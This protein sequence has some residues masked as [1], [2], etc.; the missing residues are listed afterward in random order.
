MKK[1]ILIFL[2][3]LNILFSAFPT[4]FAENE[5]P[6]VK[7]NIAVLSDMSTGK[8]LYSKNAAEKMQPGGFTKIMTAIVAIENMIDKNETVVADVNTLASYD[9]SFGHMGILAGEMLTLDNLLHGMLLYDAGDAAEVIANYTFS[10]RSKFIKKMNDKAVEIGALNTKFTNPTGFPD[11]KQYS[12]AEDIYKITKYAMDKEYFRDIVKRQRYEM[13]PTNK[14]KQNRY[15]DN[16]NKF[17]NST[18]TGGYYTSKAK[19]VKTSYI[20][21]SNC[22]VIIQY[23]NDN[24]KFMSI[25]SG[26]PFDGTTNYA[27]EDTSKLIKFASQYYA[28]VKVI[29]EEDILAEIELTNGKNADRLLL[30]ATEDI[31]INLPKG[32]DPK[33]LKT[34]V[35][36]EKNIKAPITKGKILGVVKVLYDG[37]EY[38]SAPLTSPIEVKANNIKG[39]FK[40]VWAFLT[41]PILLVSLGIL[42]IIVVWSTLIFNKKKVYKIDKRK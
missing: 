30:E 20:N 42:L 37:E 6:S 33:K 13:K 39:I 24:L 11:E 23:E 10:T 12:T 9:Y 18:S 3:I 34:K 1:R 16:T 7:S 19:G 4:A 25:V 36:L 28:N 27:Y 41:S 40:K 38:V 14:Y 5:K 8:F 29:S 32:Y 15:L 26:S 21:D 17:V 31:Y 22:G 35:K 2:V